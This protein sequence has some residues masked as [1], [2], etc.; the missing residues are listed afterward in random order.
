MANYWVHNGFLRVES[1][2]MSKSLGNFVVIRDLYRSRK[3][4]GKRWKRR[5]IR[6]AMLQTH[7]RQPID[8]SV[9]LLEQSEV[10]LDKWRD[11]V[12]ERTVRRRNQELFDRFVKALNDD[13]NTPAALAI[14]DNI[15]GN[16]APTDEDRFTVYK[17]LHL[18]GLKGKQTRVSRIAQNFYGVL[19]KITNIPPD[20]LAKYAASTK[21]F[22]HAG[23][24]SEPPG[25]EVE[26]IVMLSVISDYWEERNAQTNWFSGA[27]FVAPYRIYKTP[28]RANLEL[29]V[30]SFAR[31]IG[32]LGHFSKLDWDNFYA[33]AR[34]RPNF[35]GGKLKPEALLIGYLNTLVEVWKATNY[36]G[37]FHSQYL[38]HVRS[39]LLAEAKPADSPLERQVRRLI[40]DRDTARAEGRYEDADQIRLQLINMGVLLKDR[41]DAVTGKPVTTWEIAR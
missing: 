32:E 23:S 18:L 10:R 3:F 21:E 7:Y 25:P 4:G 20:R 41:K 6:F 19:E 12:A 29:L 2:K 27:Y 39:Q 40:A 35:K 33:S 30:D 16:D 8:W 24:S 1:E 9:R 14:V 22:D 26:L 36:D 5:V 37:G 38:N 31:R 15:V 28:T 17:I 11:F 34:S 13:L